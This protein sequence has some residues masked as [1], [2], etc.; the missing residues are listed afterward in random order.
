MKRIALIL[1]AVVAVALSVTLGA[2]GRTLAGPSLG[3][4]CGA[5]AS[6]VGDDATGRVTLGTS[7]STVQCELDFGAAWAS[8]PV[9]FANVETPGPSYAQVRSPSTT[10]IQLRSFGGAVAGNVIAYHCLAS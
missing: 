9:C 6:V 2:S 5:G 4:G 8:T 3:A 10:A 1:A 7:P